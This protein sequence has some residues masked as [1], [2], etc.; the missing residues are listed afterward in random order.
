MLKSDERDAATVIENH[1]Y[2]RHIRGNG[3]GK[4]YLRTKNIRRQETFFI[5]IRA[6]FI[7]S[8]AQFYLIKTEL[9]PWVSTDINNM[10]ALEK[11][12]DIPVALSIVFILDEIIK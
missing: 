2:G 8:A 1:P 6:P 10:T 12:R 11:D 5:I 3:F 9:A 4:F 7:G